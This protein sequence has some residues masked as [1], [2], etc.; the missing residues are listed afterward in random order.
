MYD[1]HGEESTQAPPSVI[2]DLKLSIREIEVD[3]LERNFPSF[4]LRNTSKWE[5]LPR[6]LQVALV[7]RSLTNTRTKA[8]K[9]LLRRMENL[10]KLT[11]DGKVLFGYPFGG[12]F[13]PTELLRPMLTML[14]RKKKLRELDVDFSSILQSE[15]MVP[16]GENEHDPFF[17][18]VLQWENVQS[19]DSSSR[20]QYDVDDP[21]NTINKN[22]MSLSNP[23]SDLYPYD[24]PN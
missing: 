4:V 20:S 3:D 17:Q 1:D 7:N 15:R 6:E 14:V 9:F 12:Y 8:L 24:P 11:L 10:Q 13:H 21:V 5:S 22:S 2:T 23:A 19:E 18:R 16:G